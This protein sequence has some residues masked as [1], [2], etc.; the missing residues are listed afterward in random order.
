M[1]HTEA[2]TNDSDHPGQPLYS[3]QCFHNFPKCLNSKLISCIGDFSFDT[4]STIYAFLSFFPFGPV[5]NTVWKETRF[6]ILSSRR[7]KRSPRH[8]GFKLRTPAGL[9]C[10]RTSLSC[11]MG[12]SLSWWWKGLSALGLTQSCFLAHFSLCS[13][14]PLCVVSVQDWWAFSRW[15]ASVPAAEPLGLPWVLSR[16]PSWHRSNMSSLHFSQPLN[17]EQ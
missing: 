10:D 15:T 6:H 14:V 2:H 4:Q 11:V 1:P 7:M 3:V 17:S 8:V 9:G 5:Y 16:C 12:L 13:D